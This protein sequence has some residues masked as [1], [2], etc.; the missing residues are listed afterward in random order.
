MRREDDDDDEG[1][2][3]EASSPRMKTPGGCLV[4][5]A[6]GNVIVIV[7]VDV[8]VGVLDIP[9]EFVGEVAGSG[10]VAEASHVER[11]TAARHG[12]SI[13]NRSFSVTEDVNTA[14]GAVAVKWQMGQGE[15][16]G[17]NTDA[18][19]EM[20]VGGE[21]SPCEARPPVKEFVC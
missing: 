19:R 21:V 16:R 3:D 2:N 14:D 17:A 9:F 20:E 15:K 11:L 13:I 1:G 18:G 10:S 5:S 8:D 4:A 7:G 6:C 12:C